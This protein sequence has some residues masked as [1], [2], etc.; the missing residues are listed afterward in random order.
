VQEAT[1]FLNERHT[2]V[3]RFWVERFIERNQ[4]I[5]SFQKARFLEKERHEV[6]EKDIKSYFEALAIHLQKIPSLFV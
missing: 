4:A 3:D 1:D 5:A 6:S 2:L